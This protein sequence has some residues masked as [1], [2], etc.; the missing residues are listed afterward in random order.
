MANSHLKKNTIARIKINGDWITDELELRKG[1]AD[2]CQAWLSDDLAWRV[3]IGGLPFATLS[4]EVVGIL[5]MPFREE[6]IFTAINEMDGDKALGPKASCHSFKG[7]IMEMFRDF[8][9]NETF[10]KSLNATFYVLI[11]KKGILR[12]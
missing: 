7:E 1:I 3:E 5:E 6:E 10:I 12:I 9:A 2:A 11:P 4:P 8:H